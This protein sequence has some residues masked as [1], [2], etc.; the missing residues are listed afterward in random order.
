MT[1]VRGSA[2]LRRLLAIH[3]FAHGAAGGRAAQD[4]LDNLVIAHALASDGV[5][6]EL[7]DDIEAA[8]Q[9]IRRAL[10]GPQPMGLPSDELQRIRCLAEAMEEQSRLA[11]STQ[12]LRA[13]VALVARRMGWVSPPASAA[14]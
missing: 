13:E 1:A 4:L 7:L 14:G 8:A 3:E 11:T 2:A 10:A 6:A 12:R 9:A 5:G